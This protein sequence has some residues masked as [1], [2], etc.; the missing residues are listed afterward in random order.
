[1]AF[2]SIGWIHTK[3]VGIDRNGFF[4]FY[5]NHQS[6]LKCSEQSKSAL[7]EIG[8]FCKLRAVQRTRILS[9]WRNRVR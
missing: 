6:L 8:D 9:T 2:E 5:T 7:A 3:V 1:M 4:K